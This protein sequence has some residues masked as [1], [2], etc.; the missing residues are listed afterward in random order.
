[1]IE[2]FRAEFSS[3]VET[4][5]VVQSFKNSFKKLNNTSPENSKS[6]DKN[7]P[8][9]TKI[10]IDTITL[11]K[12]HLS[13]RP[14]K[15]VETKPVPRSRNLHASL[16]QQQQNKQKNIQNDNIQNSGRRKPAD[17]SLSNT[18]NKNV[19]I[20]QDELPSI[21]SCIQI[22]ELAKKNDLPS[23]K[24]IPETRA[25][26]TSDTATSSN[27]SSEHPQRG[28][29]KLAPLRSSLEK[30]FSPEQSPLLGKSKLQPLKIQRTI[31]GYA[32]TLELP[33]PENPFEKNDEKLKLISCSQRE[34]DN[35]AKTPG[36]DVEMAHESGT[37]V[38]SSTHPI[39]M[40][41]MNSPEI[42]PKKSNQENDHSSFINFLI[43]SFLERQVPKVSARCWALY[44]AQTRTYITGKNPDEIREI[45]SLTKI[46]TCLVCLK[47]ARALNI[48][49]YSCR[50]QVSQTAASMI[51]TSANLRAGDSLI[52]WDLLH[53]LMLP[54]GNDA[55]FAL[56]EH[57][58]RLLFYQSE[59]YNNLV[60]S[61]EN[62]KISNPQQIIC[63][64]PVRYF[65][66]EMNKS[67]R[68]IG[69]KDTIFANSHGLMH[70]YNRSTARD[71]GILCCEMMTY[72]LARIIVKTKEFNSCIDNT[73][74]GV[75]K[76]RVMCWQNT[77]KL[78]WKGF[79]GLKTGITDSA[80]PCLS[81]VLN[82]DGKT[83]IC[84]VLGCRTIEHRFTDSLKLADYGIYKLLHPKKIRRRLS[85]NNM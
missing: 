36:I 47:I 23:L 7:P 61:K 84:I 12:S 29:Q 13:Q 62:S 17:Q 33:S 22:N 41:T 56:A 85:I 43:L 49:L 74:N 5:P 67:A 52:L 21:L 37:L 53:G 28:N 64:S 69:L 80:G 54:S 9:L 18:G 8:A 45:A 65:V 3:R 26:S 39:T 27:Q 81:S 40:E 58:G 59:E 77:N 76:Q 35:Q 75:V 82:K 60:H 68:E 42:K 70:K 31:N 16:N 72:D 2:N 10:I 24:I 32:S 14:S 48:D 11:T 66:R 50:I 83:I 25:R 20:F 63:K 71:L 38:A 1:M 15:F 46:M 79:D 44:D 34:L 4:L 78:L 55:A 19:S 57:F 73:Q 51:G 30:S 6:V